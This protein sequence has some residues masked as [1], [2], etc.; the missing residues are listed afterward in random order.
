MTTLAARRADFAEHL[1]TRA[2]CLPQ[3]EREAFLRASAS[4][5]PSI[6][7]DVLSML[8]RL[9][10]LSGFLESPV[11]LAPPP[12][13]FESGQEIA[14]RF[15]IERFITRG[16]MGEVYAAY[17][18]LLGEPVALK[19][20]GAFDLHEQWLINRFREEIRLGRRVSHRNICRIYDIHEHSLASGKTLLFYAMELLEGETLATPDGARRGP[21][22]YPSPLRF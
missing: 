7:A 19:T 21:C 20:I 15:R 18:Q 6:I 14:G 9:D 13:A 22:R 2:I 17:D 11:Q 5:D 4:A 16:G 12:P 8:H 3:L 10:R 1:F